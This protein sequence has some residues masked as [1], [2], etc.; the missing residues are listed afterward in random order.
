[1]PRQ[2]LNPSGKDELPTLGGTYTYDARDYYEYPLEGTYA[3]LWARRVGFGQQNI[4]Y[5]RYGVDVRRYQKI[6]RHLTLAAYGMTDLA[7]G[8]IPVYDLVYLGYG[9]RVRGRFFDRIA[10]RHVALG[11]VE[12]RFPLIPIRYLSAANSGVLRQMVPGFMQPYVSNVKFGMN[13]AFFYD[14]GVAWSK[15]E[16]PDLKTGLSGFGAGLHFHLPVVGLLRVEIAS[17]DKGK[18]QGIF[19]M[20][21]A[22]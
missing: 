5:V 22:F 1:V 4:H 15:N 19:D 8:K 3:R 13:L 14:Y 16:I 7:R 18:L 20:G 17:D 2:T 9:N 6:S 12:A 11:S 10:G 21:V